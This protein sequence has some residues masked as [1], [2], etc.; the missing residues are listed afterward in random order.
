MRSE[1]SGATCPLTHA[2]MACLGTSLPL[3]YVFSKILKLH[4]PPT[5]TNWTPHNLCRNKAAMAGSLYPARQLLLTSPS[6]VMPLC[7][8]LSVCL[9]HSLVATFQRGTFIIISVSGCLWLHHRSADNSLA[10]SLR[11]LPVCLYDLTAVAV[12]TLNVVTVH[13]WRRMAEVELYSFLNLALVGG[14]L[15]DSTSDYF[16]PKERP[17]LPSE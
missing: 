11:I 13:P 10:C 4:P 15:S 12:G 8:C 17:L 3:P 9:S 5:T 16:A 1:I 7:L 2:F 6:T 14:E